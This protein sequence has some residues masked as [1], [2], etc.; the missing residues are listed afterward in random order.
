MVY[1][2]RQWYYI[3]PSAIAASALAG[4]IYLWGEKTYG[5]Y[6][7]HTL[8]P[9]WKL[10]TFR[11]WWEWPR[12]AAPDDPVVLNP[13]RHNIPAYIK[14]LHI[15]EEIEEEVKEEAEHQLHA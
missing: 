12:E 7:P 6:K 1:H 11:K 10:A 14:N 2:T 9:C 13:M 5:K 8:S 3:V 15:V 4:A